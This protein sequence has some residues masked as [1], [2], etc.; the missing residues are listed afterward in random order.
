MYEIKSLEARFTAGQAAEAAGVEY[1][2]LNHWAKT[3]LVRPS[4]KEASGS[5][6]L[7]VYGFGDVVALRVVGCLRAG[8][9]TG[10]RLAAVAKHLQKRKYRQ[11][12]EAYLVVGDDGEVRELTQGEF[13]AALNENTLSWILDLAALVQE[14]DQAAGQRVKATRGRASLVA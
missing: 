4:I 8:G 13:V 12:G 2:S 6:S 5:D 9:F 1:H 11:I 3:G 10:E 7:R 14:V